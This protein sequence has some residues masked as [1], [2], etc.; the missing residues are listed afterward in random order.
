MKF[1]IIIFGIFSVGF[2]CCQVNKSKNETSETIE[3]TYEKKIPIS[4]EGSLGT[5]HL[6]RSDQ[7]LILHDSHVSSRNL[8]CVDYTT[9]KELWKLDS[10]VFRYYMYQN[11]VVVDHD[12]YLSI[13]EVATGKKLQTIQNVFIS[14][15]H[16]I[17][18]ELND[19]ILVN[20][21]T[22]AAILDLRT[23]N[24]V[25][26]N[27]DVIGAYDF[28]ENKKGA[29]KSFTGIE[30]NFTFE[31]SL[32]SAVVFEDESNSIKFIWSM[33]EERKYHLNSFD[34]SGNKL[35]HNSWSMDEGEQKT[36]DGFNG[37]PESDKLDASIYFIDGHIFLFEN[38][39][40]YRW[41]WGY[42]NNRITCIEPTSGEILYQRWGQSPNDSLYHTFHFFDNS[43]LY[44][45]SVMHFQNGYGKYN[46][47]DYK[48]NLVKDSLDRRLTLM[49]D[50]N[51]RYFLA[52]NYERKLVKEDIYTNAVE[53]GLWNQ[54]SNQFSDFFRFDYKEEYPFEPLGVFDDGLVVLYYYDNKK[55][56][57]VLDCYSVSIK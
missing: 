54:N 38:Y 44:G 12:S 43:I 37:H 30:N 35:K 3:I 18:K 9:G 50:F 26:T 34:T 29:V 33:D 36:Y 1:S 6:S 42:G 46:Q 53:M 49:Y 13:Y 23:G 11:N 16:I 19:K 31:G 2:I 56:Q 4:L 27:I 5:L 48:N 40:N 41:S 10:T 45:N 52:M 8:T 55:N 57:A 47:F 25:E 28:K 22:K 39:V 21:L 15:Q 20:D 7:Y 24:L 51:S 14:Y 17:G 32:L